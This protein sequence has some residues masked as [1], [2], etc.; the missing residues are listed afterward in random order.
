VGTE[1]RDEFRR[2][3]TKTYVCGCPQ[4]NRRGSARTL[5]K[6]EEEQTELENGKND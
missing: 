5:G 3:K 6:V 2:Q 1:D 4:E